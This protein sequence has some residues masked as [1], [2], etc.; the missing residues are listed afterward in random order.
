MVGASLTQ[1]F[2]N[3]AL[4]PIGSPNP[5]YDVLRGSAPERWIAGGTLEVHLRWARDQNV[6]LFGLT[7]VT[8]Q[9]EFLTSISFP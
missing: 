7:T 2:Q 9:I 6:P 4:P 5:P 8:D 1:D 3:Y